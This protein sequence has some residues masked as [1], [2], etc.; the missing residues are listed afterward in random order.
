MTL[1]C[2]S[3]C[4]VYLAALLASSPT[5]SRCQARHAYWSS[6]WT[7]TTYS[8]NFSRICAMDTSI[9]LDIPVSSVHI[10]LV[11]RM[12]RVLLTLNIWRSRYATETGCFD[13]YIRH[14]Q[15]SFQ[16]RFDRFCF[17]FLSQL[18]QTLMISV[19]SPNVVGV[20]LL[21]R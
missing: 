17:L 1:P 5:W 15:C 10:C 20:H 16:C 12:L 8:A 11:L 19:Q 9:T 14:S 4:L 13:W 2:G 18:Y 7:H 3:Y 6:L 21:P